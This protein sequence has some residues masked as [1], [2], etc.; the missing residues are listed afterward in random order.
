MRP[1]SLLVSAALL[2]IAPW[3][4]AQERYDTGFEA[5]ADPSGESFSV[6]ALSAQSTAWQVDEEETAGSTRIVGSGEQPPQAG[7]QSLL[8]GPN[9]TVSTE[10]PVSADRM[11]IRAWHRGEGIND[12]VAPEPGT[13]AAAVVAF[14]AVTPGTYTLRAFDGTA[15]NFAPASSS[16]ALEVGEWNEVFI[17]VNYATKT[18]DVAVGGQPYFAGLGFFDNTLSG[19]TGFRASSRTGSGIDTVS[20][21]P[22]TG[23][24][25]GDG[26]NDDREMQL[27]GG[28]ALDPNRIPGDVNRDGATD[29]LDALFQARAFVG[30]VE[31][32]TLNLVDVSLTGQ[33]TASDAELLFDWAAGRELPE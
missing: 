10:Q 1:L 33:A 29:L 31:A 28:N 32:S 22:S 2:S 23:D 25:D 20:F 16:P 27:L 3:V 18:Y 30:T 8:Q 21:V 5:N 11:L 24:A 14:E 15:S 9:S 6:G 4:H 19:F 7:A 13:P 17:S 12:L 26:W